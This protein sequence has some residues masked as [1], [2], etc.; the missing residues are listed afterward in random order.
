MYLETTDLLAVMIA[1]ISALAVAGMALVKQV[2]TE[3]DLRYW[4]DA[5]LRQIERE[6]EMLYE[7]DESARTIDDIIKEI[8]ETE[9]NK[10]VND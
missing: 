5:A 10:H 1:I 2:R 4:R 9:G 7:F 8:K 3:Q 6:E